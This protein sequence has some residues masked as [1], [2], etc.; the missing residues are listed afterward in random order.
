MMVQINLFRNIKG[1]HL[2]VAKIKGFENEFV[3]TQFFRTLPR[4]SLLK[5]GQSH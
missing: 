2:E 3:K 1:L 4:V 5:S